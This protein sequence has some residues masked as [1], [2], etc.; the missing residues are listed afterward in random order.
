MHRKNLVG[1]INAYDLMFMAFPREAY[2]T[3]KFNRG[4][5]DAVFHDFAVRRQI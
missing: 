4:T 3:W 5:L 2:E 1:E